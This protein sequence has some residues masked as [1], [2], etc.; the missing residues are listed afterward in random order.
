MAI[1]S[2]FPTVK[3]NLLLDFANSKTLD[4]RIT[5]TRAG[6]A[7]YYDGK[8][9]ALAEQNLFLYS[10]GPYDT[11]NGVWYLVGGTM[12]GSQTAPD[13]TSTA[14]LFKEDAGTGTHRFY[15]QGA[16]N[17]TPTVGRSVA[18]SCYLKYA[19]RQY[20][21]FNC[22]T[23]RTGCRVIFDIQ[24]GTVSDAA[25]AVS[26]TIQSVGNGWYRAK[27]VAPATS[28]SN[29]SFAIG[30]NNA[31]TG[32][33]E[34]HTGN[35]ANSFYVWGVQFEYRDAVASYVKT[36]ATQV[37]NYI[38]QLL[39]AGINQPRFTHNPTTQ[40]SLGLLLEEQRTNFQPYS[41]DFTNAV[42]TKTDVTLVGNSIIAPDGSL[43]GC[44]VTG[45]GTGTSRI[46]TLGGTMYGTAY[47]TGTISF[48][49]KAGTLSTV[50]IGD[51]G[52]G[53]RASFNL[54]TG[55]ATNA[56][57][58]TSVSMVSAGNGWYRCS[59]SY[60]FDYL[61]RIFYLQLGATYPGIATTGSVYMWGC[62]LE[63]GSAFHTSYIPTTSAAVTRVADSAYLN[64]INFSSWFTPGAGTILYD[65]AAANYIQDSRVMWQLDNG[66]SGYYQILYSSYSIG[67]NYYPSTRIPSGQTATGPN[68]NIFAFDVNGSSI[69]A[70]G[71][72]A[73]NTNAD[74]HEFS[75]A[76]RF[77]LGSANYPVRKFVYYPQKLADA[78]LTAL[79]A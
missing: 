74:P 34:T 78:N 15:N 23:W 21:Q 69:S 27:V 22:E 31:A 49:A 45:T 7:T 52:F 55:V 47:S 37:N 44:T 61:Y 66:I 68:V 48:Y 18:V 67:G 51:N 57:S 76:R 73:S 77:I 56:G 70:N 6:S 64:D 50:S 79:T 14:W 60:A 29:N 40:E 9:F 19:G 20:I 32:N 63:P 53:N 26:A 11:T 5:Y 17:W 10:E 25:N 75:G 43:T 62:Q 39:T 28:G 46:H 3:P 16:N 38:P 35:N 30:S 36:T 2:N 1:Q 58:A 12:T 8:T 65:T 33:G 59:V 4:P 41:S 72:A 24:N 71:G 13:G 42:Y 54:S